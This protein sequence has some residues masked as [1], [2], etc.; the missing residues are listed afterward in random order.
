MHHH[1]LCWACAASRENQMIAAKRHSLS[2]STNKYFFL[3]NEF[4][5]HYTLMI[6][7]I[8]ITL[9]HSLLCKCTLLI[10]FQTFGDDCLLKER[11]LSSGWISI[12]SVTHENIF[13]LL[14]LVSE[15]FH[16]IFSVGFRGQLTEFSFSNRSRR[17]AWKLQRFVMLLMRQTG[18]HE[19]R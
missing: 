13:V 9:S 14:F 6:P 17:S 2:L 16:K 15:V 3:F 19:F 12:G 5:S 1:H 10:R 18:L 4:P 11:L 7:A 8:Y